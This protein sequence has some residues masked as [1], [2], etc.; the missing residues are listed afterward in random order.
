MSGVGRGRG[1]TLPA[2]MTQEGGGKSDSKHDSKRGRSNSSDAARSKKRSSGERRKRSVSPESRD[3][4]RRY[5]K[6]SRS[7]RRRSPDRRR[8]RSPPQYRD[9]RDAP[10][11]QR[12]DWGASAALPDV[13][14][15]Y[16]CTVARLQ[17]FG[18][19]VTIPGYKDGLIHVSELCAERRV[20]DV[21]DFLSVGDSLHA[22]V[23]AIKDGGKVSLSMARVDQETK[24]LKEEAAPRE[25][26]NF[27]NRSSGGAS[28][29]P[30]PLF[31]THRGRVVRIQ[32]FGCFVSMEGYSDGMIHISQLASYR[33]EK[34]DDVVDV[35]Q[36][37]YVKVVEHREMGRVALSMKLVDQATGEDLDPSNQD[38]DAGGG[39]GRSSRQPIIAGDDLDPAITMR[40]NPELA[41]A[42]AKRFGGVGA[43]QYDL[44]DDDGA[45][46]RGAGGG[47][48]AE[49]G[50]GHYAPQLNDGHSN[51]AD[52]A[53]GPRGRGNGATL[54][55]WMTAGG[56]PSELAREKRQRKASK[57]TKKTL[58]KLAKQAKK[59]K[60]ESKK[61]KKKD[62][63]KAKA[64]KEKKEKQESAKKLDSAS[65]SPSR[66]E[67]AK[68]DEAELVE[69]I[70]A[71]SDRGASS[72][73]SSSSS[74]S[75]SSRR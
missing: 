23:T 64:K 6:R 73:S 1:A 75:A 55:A 12:R 31:S 71:K 28:Q 43:A 10:Q 16:A 4:G 22:V 33:V 65:R 61:A 48:G 19:F 46:Q 70:K 9:A 52:V 8:S 24:A 54:P 50:S 20:D 13:G 74:S 25:E 40:K 69:K 59:L 36:Q 45:G 29:L 49:P 51:A 58:K 44:L 27:R 37:V 17:P 57:E 34:P 32:P 63:K 15:I 21:N 7:P 42:A 56:I 47:G 66:A 11:S 53:A 2:W 30:P 60:K 41:A 26:M 14:T 67:A 18:A 39:K 72:S 5:R 68:K 35:G 62:K 38:Y 3:D